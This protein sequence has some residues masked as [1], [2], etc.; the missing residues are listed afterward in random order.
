M[1]DTV[2]LGSPAAAADVHSID[3]IASELRSRTAPD[4][5]FGS[6]GCRSRRIAEVLFYD[7]GLEVATGD[8]LGPRNKSVLVDGISLG[9]VIA[10]RVVLETRERGATLIGM[11]YPW[12]RVPISRSRFSFCVMLPIYV[13]I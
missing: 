10:L 2:R 7:Q 3:R 11:L 13:A 12:A 4:P 8:P 5:A 9:G 6:A 1:T